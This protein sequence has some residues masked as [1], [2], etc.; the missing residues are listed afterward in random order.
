MICPNIAE[1][2]V[3]LGLIQIHVVDDIERFGAGFEPDPLAKR[4]DP[5][6]REA[7]IQLAWTFERVA[8]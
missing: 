5:A 3:V 7:D 8:A 2:K 1:V 6:Q 4:E